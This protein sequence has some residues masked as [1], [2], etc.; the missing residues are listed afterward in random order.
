M[1]AFAGIDIK[2]YVSF[3]RRIDMKKTVLKLLPVLF[4]SACASTYSPVVIQRSDELS[5]RPSWAKIGR[6]SYPCEYSESKDAYVR[7]NEAD[8]LCKVAAVARPY[9][10]DLDISGLMED[11]EYEAKRQF[12]TEV[13]SRISSAYN[14]VSE[15]NS[16]SSSEKQSSLSATTGAVSINGI[17]VVGNYWEKRLEQGADGKTVTIEV[18]TQVAV[19]KKALERAARNDKKLSDNAKKLNQMT[20]DAVFKEE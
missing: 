7:K 18:F 14:R 12:V 20:L 2:L 5:E 3:Q 9:D 8:N 11:A 19:P 13:K 16:I 6:Q 4:L 10:D 17:R 15:S 1:I